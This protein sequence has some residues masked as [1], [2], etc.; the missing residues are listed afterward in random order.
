MKKQLLALSLLAAFA[1]MAHAQTNVTIYGLMDTGFIKET[2]SDLKMGEWN[3]SRLGFKGTEDLGG[4]YKATFQLEKRFYVNDGTINGVDWDGASNVGLAGPFG[5]VRFGRMNEIETESFRRL[6][7]FN[8]E[9]VGSMMLGSQ[10]TSRISNA[11][12]Y[13]SPKFNGFNVSAAYYLG[14][15]SN[16][17][18]ID[19]KDTAFVSAVSKG[20]DNDGFA[21][22]L[23]YDNGPLLLLANFSR[24]SDSNSSNVW[25]LGGAYKFGPVKVGLG[26]ERTDDKG[27]KFGDGSGKLKDTNMRSKQDN[28]ILSAE[29]VN[30]AHK[31]AGSFNWMKVKDVKGST[32]PYWAKDDSGDVKKYSV[33]YFYSLSK[34]TMLYGQLAY[35][36]FEDKAVAQFFRG[37]GFENDSVT[38]VQVGINHKF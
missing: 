5:A 17:Q 29:Y 9:G 10:R 8:Q 18:T 31:L 16:P 21:V 11:T 20:A 30:G 1:G 35:S 4:G 24:L 6:D 34:R 13:D 7:P 2:G 33:G 27:Y 15:N 19:T 12:R 36:D 26:Y 25:S 23:N 22:G 37:K 14:K 3:S 32:N 28:W 38:G